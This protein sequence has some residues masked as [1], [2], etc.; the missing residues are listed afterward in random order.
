MHFTEKVKTL[1][2]IEKGNSSHNEQL[3]V[4]MSKHLL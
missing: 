1:N 3:F 2:M 4:D